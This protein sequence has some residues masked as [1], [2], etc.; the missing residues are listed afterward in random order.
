VTGVQIDIGSV[1]LP[2][3]TYAATIQGELAA[4]QRYYQRYIGDVAFG[5]IGGNGVA[6]STTVAKMTLPLKVTM[7]TNPTAIDYAATTLVLRVVADAAVSGG[8]WANLASSAQSASFTYTHGSAV[9]TAGDFVK[10]LM[11]NNVGFIA[12]SAEL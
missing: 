2:F 4:C 7:R 1:A 6:I 11:N 12:F 5:E 8:T 10:P 9:F 3:R